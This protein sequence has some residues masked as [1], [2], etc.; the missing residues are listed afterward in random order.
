[1]VNWERL[2]HGK[3]INA[4]V[5]LFNNTVLNVFKSYVPN[6]Y[7][8]IDDKVPVWM[9]DTIKAKIKTKDLFFK[10]YMQH[11]RFDSEFGFLKA[12]ITELNE[13]TSSTKT[14][15]YENLAKKLNNPLL[16]AKTY[17]SVLNYL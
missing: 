3:D 1:M 11:E 4:Q 6:E 14:L 13:L 7:I 17:W 8:A 10:Q 5:S 15:Y 2:I 16:Q 12:L 9:N